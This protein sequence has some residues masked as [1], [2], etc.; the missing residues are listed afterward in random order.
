M[1]W[2]DSMTLGY[3]PVDMAHREFVERVADLQ[4]CADADVPLVLDR[5]IEHLEAHFRE[6]NELMTRYDFPPVDCH[7]SEHTA[8]LRSAGEVRQCVARGDHAQ[9]RSFADALAGWFPGHAD[10]MDAALAHWIVKH[11]HGGKPVVFRREVN[12]DREFRHGARD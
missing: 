1:E 12:I 5:M 10:F 8:V 7:I 11:L 9:A 4:R 6:E 3:E 2:T